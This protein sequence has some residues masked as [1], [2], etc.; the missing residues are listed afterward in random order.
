MLQ[1]IKML[2]IRGVVPTVIVGVRVKI[3]MMMKIVMR[4][5]TTIGVVRHLKK[6]KRQRNPK[7][8]KSQNLPRIR[9]GKGINR[10]NV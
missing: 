8:P 1:I 6:V 2:M 3:I 4:N 5:T 10:Q 9:R 7:V